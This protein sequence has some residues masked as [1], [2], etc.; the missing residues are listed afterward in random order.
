MCHMCTRGAKMPQINFSNFLENLKSEL[1]CKSASELYRSLGGSESL[2]IERRNFMMLYSDERKPSLELLGALFRVLPSHLRKNLFVSFFSSHFQD[3]NS[4]LS[5]YVDVNLVGSTAR[6]EKSIWDTEDFQTLTGP[7]LEALS[8]DPELLRTHHALMLYDQIPHE[9]VPEHVQGRLRKLVDMG[10][11]AEEEGSFSSTNSI[12]L[13]PFKKGS[14]PRS[15][16][17]ASHE[18]MMQTVRNYLQFEGDDDQEIGLLIQLVSKDNL[19]TIVN[20]S[21]R[22]KNW[23]RSLTSKPTDTDSV[24]MLWV[25]CLRT[26]TK[27]ELE[28]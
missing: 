25:S 22:F 23:I 16:I 24:P 26:M 2:N 7:Q 18:V 15:T 14:A 1:N 3:S 6:I 20:E 8:R 27:K 19:E 28:V 12:F 5:E 4:A 11:A 9:S 21:R 10:I 13:Y 17:A